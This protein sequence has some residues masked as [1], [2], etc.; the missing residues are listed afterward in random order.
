M[1]EGA[2]VASPG[3]PSQAHRLAQRGLLNDVVHGDCLEVLEGV[4]DDAVDLVLCDLPFGTTRNGWDSTIDLDALWAHYA[5]VVKPDGAIILHGQGAFTAR[6][7]L[8]QP[9]WFRFKLVWVKSKPTNFLN[10]RRQPLRAHEDLCV[11]YRQPPVYHP[12]MREGAPYSKGVRK[13]QRTGSYGAFAPS[14]VASEDGARYP[15]DVLYHKTAESEGPV[16]HPTQKPV[17][18]ARE[19]VRTWSRPGEVVL[20]N[21]C[22]SASLLVGAV[23]EG[24]NVLGIERD[25]TTQRFEAEPL[26]LIALAR[27]RLREADADRPAAS[28]DP[29]LGV[30]ALADDR[31]DPPPEASAGA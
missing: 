16:W 28:P 4:P 22:G 8:S 26:D 27:R 18:L 14:L 3:P 7:I 30:G 24:R 31:P 29:V 17:G 13:D 5:R 2:H 1:A 20:D 19:L 6:L 12:Q 21:A 25:R 10:A 15:T 23:A 11:F 9:A